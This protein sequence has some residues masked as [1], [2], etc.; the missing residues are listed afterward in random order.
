[1]LSEFYGGDTARVRGFL[2]KIMYLQKRSGR[3]E[4]AAGLRSKRS[5]Q[6]LWGAVKARLHPALGRRSRTSPSRTGTVRPAGQRR[7]PTASEV[8]FKMKHVVDAVSS[9][10]QNDMVADDYVAIARRRGTQTTN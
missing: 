7:L 8:Q 4:N 6:P 2:G 9:V 3:A 10:N 1:V 5:F